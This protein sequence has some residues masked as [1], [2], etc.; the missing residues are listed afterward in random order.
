MGVCGQSTELVGELLKCWPCMVH[1]PECMLVQSTNE[2]DEFNTSMSAS[3]TGRGNNAPPTF[4]DTAS[5]MFAPSNH[6]TSSPASPRV[7]FQLP[8]T[9]SS[10]SP[11]TDHLP[12]TFSTAMS[13]SSSEQKSRRRTWHIADVQIGDRLLSPFRERTTHHHSS[14]ADPRRMS[15]RQSV[16][17]AMMEEEDEEGESTV[18]G[19][20]VR[21][22]AEKTEFEAVNVQHTLRF[23]ALTEMDEDEVDS[24]ITATVLPA[25][26]TASSTP[27]SLPTTA[28]TS[29]ACPAWSAG[30]T[31]SEK[32]PQF[33]GFINT[34]RRAGR[35]AV[36]QSVRLSSRRQTIASTSSA[37]SPTA[38]R[39]QTIA[40]TSSSSTTVAAIGTGTS[41][42]P[43]W[44]AAAG[45]RPLRPSSTITANTAVVRPGSGATK[46]KPRFDVAASLARPVTWKMH[47]GP[48]AE[49]VN[50][51]GVKA[52]DGGKATMDR[53]KG[54]R[55]EVRVRQRREMR[56]KSIDYARN[57][58]LGQRAGQENNAPAV[59][60]Q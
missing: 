28:S 42:G 8:T 18:G 27:S 56:Q 41:H 39:R 2:D 6:S 10:N 25:A 24:P 50:G 54:G 38:L 7:S 49:R 15:V 34:S 35:P 31:D 3:S 14:P 36:R 22:R 32:S 40:P 13:S 55:D 12:L 11:D 45:P 26:S 19:G 9:N 20:G 52:V 47:K 1:S 33:V 37:A 5:L 60:Q 17:L 30:T 58:R 51:S 43:S 23:S 44:P 29:S 53:E 57:V 16:G 59:K 48:L 21:E 4:I 46:Q